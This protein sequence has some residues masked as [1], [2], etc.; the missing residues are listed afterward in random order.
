VIPCWKGFLVHSERTF[1]KPA[2]T[3]A[4]ANDSDNGFSREAAEKAD[5]SCR[6]TWA[7]IRLTLLWR[8][9]LDGWHG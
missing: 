4:L 1:K 6:N 2:A 5:P 9:A 8:K 7:W 3:V